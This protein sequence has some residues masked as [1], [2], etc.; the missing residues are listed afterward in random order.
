MGTATILIAS[1]VFFFTCSVDLPSLDKNEQFEQFCIMSVK[2]VFR[3][4]PWY[5]CQAF[6]TTYAI[7]PNQINP[8]FKKVIS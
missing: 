4:Q 3:Q 7:K 1:C 6:N 2:H 8:V 5:C